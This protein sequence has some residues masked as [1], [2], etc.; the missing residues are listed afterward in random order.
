MT[1]TESESDAL[2]DTLGVVEDA[3]EALAERL[4]LA[5]R[6]A[7]EER[8]ALTVP[9][10]VM[11][12]VGTLEPELE[13]VMLAETDT[14]REDVTD[15]V[16]ERL[17]DG[18]ALA[19]AEVDGTT[20]TVAETEPL[21]VVLPVRNA[22]GVT[23]LVVVPAPEILALRDAD[24]EKLAI[25]DNEAAGDVDATA[26]VLPL[27]LLEGELE[28]PS[29]AETDTL[30]DK[31]GSTLAVPLTV[32]EVEADCVAAV[33]SDAATELER[34]VLMLEEALVVALPAALALSK[35]LQEPLADFD[36]LPTALALDVNEELTLK[37]LDATG[38]EGRETEAVSAAVLEATP[39]SDAE[40]LTLAEAER[41]ALRDTVAEPIGDCDA[42]A[43]TVTDAETVSDGDAVAEPVSDG[44]PLPLG[45]ALV[46]GEALLL[47]LLD[48]VGDEDGDRETV[49]A[50]EAE[51]LAMADADGVVLRETV[52][53]LD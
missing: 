36:L 26:L 46:D 5:V 22:D 24:R 38:D 48:A 39:E 9:V 11:D 13:V 21:A 25:R 2:G 8:V 30:V 28:V 12:D 50:A 37:L 32:L 33:D 27:A 10:G 7:V 20:L 51:V 43:E 6:L 34:A 40:A 44:A 53:E 4:V 31:L 17:I 15:G 23:L 16:P 49:C 3:G 45:L 35:P 1:E 42:D 47:E 29:V 19:D 41:D 52:V 14:V 18:V